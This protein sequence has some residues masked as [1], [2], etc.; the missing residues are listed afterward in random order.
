MSENVIPQES[1][2]DAP[3]V[4]APEGEGADTS[5]ISLEE[6]NETLGRDYKD[7]ETALKSVKETYT[8]IGK[9]DELRQNLEQVMETT[10]QDEST[11]LNNLQKLM[12]QSEVPAE[13]Q[14]QP[15]PSD[16]ISS[17]KE[18]LALKDA[19]Y[20]ED[21]FF[22]KNPDF[23]TIKGIIKPLKN[24]SDFKDMSWDEFRD[25]DTVKGV[26]ETYSVANEAQSKKSVVESN[27]RLGAAVDKLSQA[28]QAQ[29][30]GNDM[31]AKESAVG[32][33]VDMLSE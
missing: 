12:S 1:V 25:T 4:S 30:E 3:H 29:T 24:T 27:P 21:R 9:R 26:F 33:V 10:G 6:L 11:V 23:E 16:E 7:V 22:D 13:P 2:P 28:R 17:L 15:Q 5:R 18:Q 20:A 8:F 32:A 31:V 19:Q 14:A